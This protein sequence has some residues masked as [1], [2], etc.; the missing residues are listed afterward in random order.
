MTMEP[1]REPKKVPQHFTDKESADY[2]DTH[3]L[4]E[5][6]LL[7]T[8]L[9]DESEMPPK[10]ADTKTI[11]IRI[12]IDTI[13]RLQK[14]A[15]RRHKGYQTLLKQFVIERLYEEEKRLF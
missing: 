4:T 10:R 14:V 7:N 15:E 9:L 5:E 12:D 13:E 1:I 2:W 3:E 11:T 6:F 8:R